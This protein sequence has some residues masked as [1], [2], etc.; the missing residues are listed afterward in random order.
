MYNNALSE[1]Q[2]GKLKGV[3]PISIA[4]LSPATTLGEYFDIRLEII[5]RIG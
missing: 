1:G 3:N 2:A 4:D 5:R